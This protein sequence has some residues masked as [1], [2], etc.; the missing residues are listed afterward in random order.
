MGK[1]I[2]F[3]TDVTER[4]MQV[5][6]NDETE[7]QGG[8]L[9]YATHRGFVEPARSAGCLTIHTRKIVHGVSALEGGV[10]CGLFVL[11]RSHAQRSRNNKA[12]SSANRCQDGLARSG[13]AG[14]ALWTVL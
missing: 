7:Y 1:C 4:T 5:E 12:Q 3:H 10:R 6:L 13:C 14:C 8:R 9:V 2:N 11:G